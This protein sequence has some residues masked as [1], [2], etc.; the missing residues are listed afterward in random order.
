MGLLAS[1]I[2]RS[3]TIFIDGALLF[4]LRIAKGQV[5]GPL[6]RRM[7][8]K[9]LMVFHFLIAGAR[10]VVTQARRMIP[11][12]HGRLAGPTSL[13]GPAHILLVLGPLL[14][15]RVPPEIGRGKKKLDIRD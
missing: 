6:N 10:R 9:H 12:I 7:P 5:G 13:G 15:T 2:H 14:T 4:F 3:F 11:T 1:L 8:L